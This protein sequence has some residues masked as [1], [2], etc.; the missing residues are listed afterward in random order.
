VV[1][2]SS[3]TLKN[4]HFEGCTFGSEGVE[5]LGQAIAQS[6]G[7]R[8]LTLKAL[9][10]SPD[11]LQFVADGI[12]RSKVLEEVSFAFTPLGHGGSQVIGECL[13]A[14]RH[15]H[16]VNFDFCNVGPGIKALM[17]GIRSSPSIAKL[18]LKGNQ[19]GDG[20]TEMLS[21]ILPKTRL[22]F[23]N[24]Y[25]NCIQHFGAQAL[26]CAIA[27]SP[28]LQELQL[29][30]NNVGTR[31]CNYLAEGITK[32]S[33]FRT[34]GLAWNGIDPDGVAALAKALTP[35]SNLSS[36][37]LSHNNVN[38]EG[39]LALQGGILQSKVLEKLDLEGCNMD[40]EA[41]QLLME[42]I[43]SCPSLL[44]LNLAMAEIHPMAATA[45]AA[46][47]AAS[48]S[49]TA[50]SLRHTLLS[51]DV[52]EILAQGLS[53]SRSLRHLDLQ[54]C[55]LALTGIT[56]LAEG[57]AKAKRLETL[58]LVQNG[59]G[60]EGAKALANG[61]ARA[62]CFR[63]L[64]LLYN[65]LGPSGSHALMQSMQQSCTFNSMELTTTDV[66]VQRPDDQVGVLVH[67]DPE[68]QHLEVV[69]ARSFTCSRCK[70]RL[71]AEQE[72]HNLIIYCVD[73]EGIIMEVMTPEEWHRF[74]EVPL[75]E[76]ANPSVVQGQ[77]LN[78]FMEQRLAGFYN[79]LCN[80]IWN[81]DMCHTQFQWYCDDPQN[82]RE[83][84]TFIYRTSDLILFCNVTT[85]TTPHQVPMSFMS[86]K[87][88]SL[89]WRCP[90]C[91]WSCCNGGD[92][93]EPEEFYLWLMTEWPALMRDHDYYPV[94]CEECLQ[95]WV[96]RYDN[97]ELHAAIHNL[98]VHQE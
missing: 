81:G 78:S 36:L 6:P 21:D 68:D 90:F 84:F 25:D 73:L 62:P 79:A 94:V 31:G 52:A 61:I 44:S 8:T 7:L 69:K 22:Q 48:T 82:R 45:L 76:F 34:L 33:S 15:L 85:G 95:D 37:N 83:M 70:H 13:S 29:G 5:I 89:L 77:P 92:W 12:K 28:H 14:T 96:Q 51:E 63:S 40:E 9:K 58:N 2:S 46:T 43:Q 87:P 88:D 60:E 97:P 66:A 53:Q 93:M 74:A 4:L 39:A 38:T 56:A 35:T 23:V 19:L 75:P 20:G 55:N 11:D 54:G 26:G 32:S 64:N 24:L 72:G 86:G 80:L 17:E 3:K 67:P 98:R 10:L 27:I 42:A 47:L 57:I 65:D 16:T 91:G 49:I 59:I 18:S 71:Y 1:L 30:Q 41:V 50:L